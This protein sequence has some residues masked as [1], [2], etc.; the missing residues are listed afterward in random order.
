[1]QVT[2]DARVCIHAGNCV[3]SLPAVFKVV[4]GRF[5]IDQQG[6]SE[7]AIRHTVAACPSGA[8]RIT[9]D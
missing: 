7:A 2:Y 8:L 3:K 1:M 4:D 6:A 9:G 5:V